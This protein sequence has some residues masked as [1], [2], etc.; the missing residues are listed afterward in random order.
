[1]PQLPDAPPVAEL[2]GVV[3]RRG[4]VNALDGVSL[5]FAP[6]EV[7]A[8]LGPNGAGKSTTVALLTGRLSPD[9]GDVHLF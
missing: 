3:K 7:T 4:R 2:I 5:A 1:M 9:R 6:G 8:L